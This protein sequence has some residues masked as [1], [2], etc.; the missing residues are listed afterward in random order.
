MIVQGDVEGL[1]FA[2]FYTKGEKV[3]AVAT[4]GMDPVGI[5]VAELLRLGRMPTASELKSGKVR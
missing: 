5:K 4:I 2:A 3:L 1:K